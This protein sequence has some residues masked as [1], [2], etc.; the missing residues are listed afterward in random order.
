MRSS[1]V[2]NEE[3]GEGGKGGAWRGVVGEVASIWWLEVCVVGGKWGREEERG[4]E[5]LL[6]WRRAEAPEVREG[7]RGPNSLRF[8]LP[9]DGC[10]GVRLCQ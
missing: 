7:E 10:R 5:E 6:R 8:A 1:W 9:F 3:I 2:C 4:G